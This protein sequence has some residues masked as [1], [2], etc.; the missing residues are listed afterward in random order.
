V[1][2]IYPQ[3]TAVNGSLNIVNGTSLAQLASSS[4]SES[5]N[6]VNGT[7]V[8]ITNTGQVTISLK[9]ALTSNGQHIIAATITNTGTTKF[10]LTGLLFKGGASIPNTGAVGIENVE[11]YVI[12]RLLTRSPGQYTETSNNSHR[13]FKPRRIFLCIHQRKMAD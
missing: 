11:A 4:M 3:V 8:P 10:Y 5:V 7:S 6:R 9:H 1:T 2:P 12:D 13:S